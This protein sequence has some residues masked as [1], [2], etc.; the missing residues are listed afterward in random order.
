M[1][2]AEPPPAATEQPDH[3]IRLIVTDDLGRSRLTVFFRLILAIPHFVWLLL[4]TIVALL[5]VIAAWFATLLAGRCPDGLH[6]FIARYLR[7]G[8]HVNAYLYLIAN[9]FPKFS[10]RDAYSVD[11]EVDPP[12]PQNRWATGFRVILAIPALIVVNVLQQVLQIIAFLGWFVCIALGRMPKG[13]RDLEVYC[14]RY[15]QQTVAFL[16]LLTSRYPSFGG[17]PIN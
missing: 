14:L 1:P 3:P 15:G 11:L 5:A 13:M 12:A 9:P 7:Y 6:N 17:P 10:G 2:P 8:T 16:S 4:W